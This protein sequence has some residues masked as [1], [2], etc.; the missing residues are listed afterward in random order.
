MKIKTSEASGVVLDW[1]VA[2]CDGVEFD[3]I[4]HKHGSI[5]LWLPREFNQDQYELYSPSNDWAQ[6]GPIIER[7]IKTLERDG[8]GW[9]ARSQQG[10]TSIGEAPLIAAMRC[11]VASKLG[12]VVGVPDELVINAG[13]DFKV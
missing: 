5:Y 13:K 11:Y 10:N 2:R 12:D 7:D 3:H 1:V 4:E 6:G 9:F 8:D